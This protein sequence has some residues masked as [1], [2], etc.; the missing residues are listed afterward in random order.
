M[1]E[2]PRATRSV[3]TSEKMAPIRVRL[4]RINCDHARACPPDGQSSDWL[5]RLKDALGT[6]SS[7][8][9][10]AALYQLI[11]AAR[12][13]GTGISEIAVNA[14]LA[15]I[16]SAKPQGE[17]ECALVIQMA[18]T[19]SAAMLVLKRIGSGGPDR[20]AAAM[21]SAA[22]RLL[23]AYT[24]QVETLRRLRSGGSQ[25]VRVEH[26]HVNEG[27]Q[28]VIGAVAVNRSPAISL[29]ESDGHTFCQKDSDEGQT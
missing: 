27:G 18:C 17:I 13:P 4:R 15:F 11:A 9:V 2:K 21:A 7:A 6:A 10:E 19:H 20:K 22:S 29:S 26:V 8:F 3:T 28:A 23:R 25:L 5:Q 1:R 24:I 12:L 16:E 14:S